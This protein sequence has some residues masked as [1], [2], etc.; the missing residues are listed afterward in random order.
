MTRPTASRLL[1]AAVGV[2]ALHQV[3]YLLAHPS[4]IG[5]AVASEGHGY[6]APLA[7]VLIP[8]AGSVALWAVI[9]RLAAAGP[10][11]GRSPGAGD[12]LLLF[13]F[14]EVAERAVVG[15]SPTEVL[16][17]PAVWLGLALAPLFALVGRALARSL[18]RL[19]PVGTAPITAAER[20]VLGLVAPTALPSPEHTLL[21]AVLRV[22][23]PPFSLR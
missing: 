11:P 17:E 15:R 1:S 4:A 10:R 22:R 9:C 19:D 3:A 18:D 21:P 8:V 23:G 5:R 14:M 13:A 20:P 7:T 2:I 6:L 16:V 12:Y